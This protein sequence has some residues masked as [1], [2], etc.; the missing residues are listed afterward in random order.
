MTTK[1]SVLKLKLLSTFIFFCLVPIVFI[2]VGNYLEVKH[3]FREMHLAH[4]ES[5]VKIK[6]NQIERY[7]QQT[8][9]DIG[10]IQHLPSVQTY[11]KSPNNRNSL[12]KAKL[13]EQIKLLVE[14]RNIND[15]YIVDNAGKVV[16]ART[17]CSIQRNEVINII[18]AKYNQIYF[19]NIY[20]GHVNNVDYLYLASMPILDETKRRLGTVIVE[21][22]ANPLFNLI[23]DYTGLGETGET[24][25]GKKIG[26]YAVFLNP[27]RYDQNASLVRKVR[28]GD[29]YAIPMQNA[30]TG[31]NGSNL[32]MDYRGKW[33]LAAW[34]YIPLTQWG[35]VA[36]TDSSELDESLN[37]Y[38]DAIIAISIIILVFGIAA[39]FKVAMDLMR[40]IVSLDDSAHIDPLTHLPNRRLLTEVLELAIKKAKMKPDAM[41]AVLFLDLDGFKHV[42]DTYGHGTGDWLLKTVAQRLRQTV[43]SCDTIARLGGDEFVILLSGIKDVHNV[44]SISEKIIKQINE[45][46]VY[47][48]NSIYIGTSIGISMCSTHKCS[49]VSELLKKADEAMYV[50]KQ[51]GKNQFK[52]AE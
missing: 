30:V 9:K 21:C 34:R 39:S 20:K 44:M 8:Q 37:T 26:K 49:D 45:P 11:L 50:A 46:F 5:I 17:S 19:S 41:F 27:L 47:N 13:A 35:I 6:A 42:N 7:F 52:F 4:L 15:I 16:F 29:S 33:V 1:A 3:R 28:I 38:M 23:Q 36:K 12:T 43:R 25:L 22:T 51:S 31:S 24:L 14:G 32:T 48:D 40:P 18:N 2:S 10:T